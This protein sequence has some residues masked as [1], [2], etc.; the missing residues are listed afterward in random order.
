[1]TLFSDPESEVELVRPL[2]T[3]QGDPERPGQGSTGGGI[4]IFIIRGGSGG[5]PFSGKIRK[6]HKRAKIS[7]Q[8]RREVENKEFP[9]FVNIKKIDTGK[10][11]IQVWRWVQG[12][13]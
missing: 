12:P 1:M 11:A 6:K 7:S 4:P 8:S 13:F 3:N 10:R 9:V 2:N 5:S